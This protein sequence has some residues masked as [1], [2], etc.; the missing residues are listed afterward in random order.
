MKGVKVFTTQGSERSSWP[1]LELFG[2]KEWY[3]AQGVAVTQMKTQPKE[4]D[5]VKHTELNAEVFV[6]TCTAVHFSS[7][8]KK[9]TEWR[10]KLNEVNYFINC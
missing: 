5:A 3:R 2:K 10:M 7:F 4:L 9:V 1:V 6:S 8:N